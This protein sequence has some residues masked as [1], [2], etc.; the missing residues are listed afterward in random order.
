[1]AARPPRRLGA[2]FE[3]GDH[4]EA[5][6]LVRFEV[7]QHLGQLARVR[8]LVHL[9]DE[10]GANVRWLGE[11]A[12]EVAACAD[13]KRGDTSFRVHSVPVFDRLP[14]PENGDGQA[15]R[16]ARCPWRALS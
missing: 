6:Q 3:E 16:I 1:M 8:A 4:L 10:V 15:G 13:R 11:H 9:P 5:D 2:L 7:D 12:E 14:P